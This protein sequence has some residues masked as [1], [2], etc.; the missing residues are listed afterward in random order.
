[1]TKRNREMEKQKGDGA[2][3]RVCGHYETSFDRAEAQYA[4]CPSCSRAPHW[5]RVAEMEKGEGE[6]GT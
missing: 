5:V 6:D 4:H 1:M 2:R 3:C